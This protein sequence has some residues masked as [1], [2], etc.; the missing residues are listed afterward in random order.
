MR[1]VDRTS[2]TAPPPLVTADGKGAKELE[3]VRAY[4]ADPATAAQNFP[5]AVYKDDAVKAALEKLFHGKCAYC[6]TFYNTQAPVDVEH[7]R[8]K[9]AVEGAPNHRGYWWLA[10]IWTNLLPSCID[11]N[12]RRKQAT[13]AAT[14]SLGALHNAATKQINTGKKDAFPV[15]GT[16]AKAE[17]DNL[18]L[19]QAY[20]IDPTRDD[21]NEFLEYYIDPN[22]LISLIL[23][24]RAAG[25][26]PAL[27]ALGDPANVA[28]AAE[29]AGVSIRGA[30]SIQVYGLNRLGLVQARTRV[31]RH[32]EFLRH[33]IAEIDKVARKLEASPDPEV[34]SATTTLDRLI[35]RILQEIADMVKPDAQYSALVAHWKRHFLNELTP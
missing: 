8:P 15:A 19:E 33:L 26:A 30:I 24:R 20:L 25:A 23:P 31:L 13:P 32:L 27:P 22:H 1:A 5:F 11:C 35:E 17:A 7:F 3:A 16:R 12:R 9:G 21:P 28:A 29:A 18:N 10:M 6:E 14:P 34:R 4:R 2:I